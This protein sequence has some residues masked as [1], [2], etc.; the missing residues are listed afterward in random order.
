ME[1]GKHIP[2]HMTLDALLDLDVPNGIR[3]H[4]LQ[5]EDDLK[6]VGDIRRASDRRL[7]YLPNFGRKSLA[8]VREYLGK[9]QEVAPATPPDAAS[10]IDDLRAR[11][12]ALEERVFNAA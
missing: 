1:S 6:T 2:D 12:I 4:S 3:L 10:I 5:Y 9:H 7:L 11:V 8:R